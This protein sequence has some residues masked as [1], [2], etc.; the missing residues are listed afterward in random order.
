[1]KITKKIAIVVGFIVAMAATSNASARTP[2]G[3]EIFGIGLEL[4][5]P[6]AMT[7]K[8]MPSEKFGIQFFIGAGNWYNDY[9]HWNGHGMFLTGI[10][11]VAHPVMIY[12]KWKTC[13]LNLTLGG[14]LAVG[15]FRGW[16]DNNWD[17]NW[18]YYDRQYHDG[19]YYGMLFVRF[20][21]GVNLWFK[22]FP[23]ETFVEITP[24]LRFINPDPVGFHLFWVAAG[25]RWYF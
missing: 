6:T 23:L 15:V 20:V 7:M 18:Y 9:Y 16:Y 4:G 24:A 21:T 14:G 19:E 12:D 22:K 25:G 3:N 8:I 13:A 10:D 1:M 17:Y 5:D 11:F 2:V